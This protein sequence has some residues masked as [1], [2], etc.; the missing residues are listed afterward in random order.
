MLSYLFG[1]R[2]YS[3]SYFTNLYEEYFV[4]GVNF[5]LLRKERYVNEIVKEMQNSSKIGISHESFTPFDFTP[6]NKNSMV[7]FHDGII[8]YNLVF[9]FYLKE[10]LNCDQQ[11]SLSSLN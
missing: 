8:P 6:K 11:L 3:S 10:G 9:D 5:F 1:Q 4:Q 2:Y 7:N